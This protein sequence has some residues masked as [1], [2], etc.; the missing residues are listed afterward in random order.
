V[1]KLLEKDGRLWVVGVVAGE[2]CPTKAVARLPFL[3]AHDP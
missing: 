1:R 3:S 2:V